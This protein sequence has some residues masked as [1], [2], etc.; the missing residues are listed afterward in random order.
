[1]RTIVGHC[2]SPFGLVAG[3]LVVLG[4][5]I[6]GCSGVPQSSEPQVIRSVDRQGANASTLTQ[7]KPTPGADPRSIV[8]TFLQAAAV[9]ADGNHS[10]SRQFL[11]T[12]TGRKW[13]DNPVVILDDYRIQ[14]PVLRGETG[15][16]SVTGRRV[17]QVDANG[18]YAPT[19]KADGAG[20]AEVFSFGLVKEN[21]EWRINVLQPG[22]LI[23]LAD[24]S[25]NYKAVKLYFFDN[26]ET[27]LVPD[28]RYSALDGQSLASWMLPQ[29][30]PNAGRPELAQSTITEFPDQSDARRV[31]VTVGDPIVVEIPGASQFDGVGRQR[32]AIQLAYTLGPIQFS[33]S[34]SIND[35]GKPVDIPS[36][37]NVFSPL[38]FP[39]Y[40]PENVPSGVQ[41]YYLRNGQLVNG[42]DDKPVQGP[43]G[44][45]AYN[46]TAVGLRRAGSELNVAGT[47]GDKLYVGL[48]SGALSRVAVPRGPLSRPEWRPHDQDAWVGVGGAIYRVAPGGARQ[49]STPSPLSNG[50]PP[51][52]ILALRF[53][54]DG[55]RLAVVLAGKDGTSAIW[56]GSVVRSGSGAD[57][58]VES[59]KPVTPD[60]L[61]VTDVGWSDSTTLLMVAGRK[62]EGAFWS[63]QSDGSF[64]TQ[65]GTSGL[66]A[67]LQ[68]ITAT[69]GQPPIVA[70]GPA[71]W[72]QQGGSWVS[73]LGVGEVIGSS[74]AYAP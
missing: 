18:I 23:R 65:R 52:Q 74:P 47:A 25:S 32:L 73:L 26:T 56:V 68:S 1:V 50:L 30:L 2:R 35:S 59:F 19:R 71:I 41:A 13:Q 34:L 36:V 69:P 24:F 20:E 67:G 66:P 5:L 37:G 16:V 15:T 53:S 48:A 12:D 17:G 44:T 9:S 10:A 29:L 14:V 57:P 6:S 45:G 62:G 8:S 21:G 58:A 31:T 27:T 60:S 43:V 42:I 4:L 11:T 39:G 46:L 72:I 51:G 28:L 54:P 7:P 49:V 38:S 55:V 22:V 33:A 40:G 64:L 61:A 3:I 63:V 70:A